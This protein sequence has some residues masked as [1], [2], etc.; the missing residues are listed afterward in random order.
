MGEV[1]ELAD[2]RLA[3]ARRTIARLIA[4][5]NALPEVDGLDHRPLAVAALQ[6]AALA[7]EAIEDEQC[8]PLPEAAVIMGDAFTDLVENGPEDVN[9]RPKL[10]PDRRPILTPLSGGFL[11]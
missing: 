5:I 6:V 7:V 9:R 10:T 2:H 1:L 11:R 3:A 4:D 8:W